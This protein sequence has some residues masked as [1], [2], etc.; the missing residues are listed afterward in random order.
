ML[1]GSLSV[2]APLVAAIGLAATLV[3][4]QSGL[5]G[6]WTGEEKASSGTVPVVLQLSVK[7]AGVTGTVTIGESPAQAIS[8]GKA[9]GNRLTFTTTTLLN[10][11]EVPI[12]W[13]G[14]ARGDELAL[15][16]VFGSGRALPPIVVRRSK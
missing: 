7:D 15:E 14:E 2:V 6:K 3:S 4:A 11:K 9:D 16:R 10:G 5:A 1:R 12:A 13:D 8:E